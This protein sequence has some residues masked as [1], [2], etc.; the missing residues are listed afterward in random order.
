[1]T[2][3]RITGAAAA[4]TLLLSVG[5]VLAAPPAATA[6]VAPCGTATMVKE[7][8][9]NGTTWQLC[10]RMAENSG[11]ILEKV[12]VSSKRFPTPVQVLETIRVAQLNVPY[13]HGGME[14]NDV[15]SYGLGGGYAQT[16]TGDDCKGGSA[17]TGS[18]GATPPVQRKVLCG[19][20]E[21]TGL[22][23]RSADYAEDPA[24]AKVYTK[25]G[26]DLVLR[27]IG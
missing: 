19:S 3:K 12:L 11:L 9:P 26:H 22:A 16:L 4:A 2:V 23:Y 5:A 13:D 14:F 25:Q 15:T 20:A 10:W 21:P 8:L 27:S 6:A 7:T 17:R 24:A 18:D 1:M